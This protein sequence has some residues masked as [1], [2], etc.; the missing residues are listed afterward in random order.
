[1][2]AQALPWEEAA[3]GQRLPWEE[4]KGPRPDFAQNPPPPAGP[5]IQVRSSFG[6]QALGALVAQPIGGG[7]KLSREEEIYAPMPGVSE[8]AGL[9]NALAGWT[10]EGP[11]ALGKGFYHTETAKTPSDLA[12]GY[13]EMASGA[14]TT[15]L[16][17]LPFMAAAAPVATARV[18]AGGTAGGALAHKGAEY[19]GARPEYQDV[20]GDVGSLAGG[21]LAAPGV[22]TRIARLGPAVRDVAIGDQDAQALRGLG[23]PPTSKQSLRALDEVKTARPFLRGVKSEAELQTRIPQAKT[24]IWQPYK[25]VIDSPVGD[26]Q[27]QGPDGPTTIRELEAARLKSAAD[28]RATRKLQPQDQA[29]LERKQGT[30]A[31]LMERDRAI[32]AV[33]DPELERAG[34]NPQ[35]IRRVHGSVQGIESRVS[36]KSTLAEPTKPYGLGHLSEVEL[37]KPTTYVTPF[38]K[39]G[40]DLA[41]G[42]PWWSGRPTDVELSEGFRNAGPRPNFTRPVTPPPPIAGLLPAHPTPLGPVPEVAEPRPMPPPVEGTT[43]AQRLGLLLNHAP[44]ELGGEVLPPEYPPVLQRVNRGFLPAHEDVPGWQIPEKN[45][46]P[47]I[48][49]NV[50]EPQGE[51]RNFQIPRAGGRVEP[52]S[53]AP[54]RPLGAQPAAP[55]VPRIRVD[56]ASERPTIEAIRN[57]ERTQIDTGTRPGNEG[58][59]QAVQGPAQPV[60]PATP[61][62]ETIVR[63]PGEQQAY[64]ASYEIR[65]LADV[66]PSHS[67]LNFGPNKKYGLTNDRDYSNPLNQG[68]IVSASAPG[69]FDPNFLITDNPDAANGPTIIDHSGNALGGNARTMILQRVYQHNP[70]GAQAYRNLLAQKAQQFGIDPQAIANMKQPVLVRKITTDNP[71]LKQNAVTDFNKVGTAQ[72][73]PAERAIADSRR[74]SQ[75]T[76]DAIAGRLEQGGPDA[77]MAQILEGRSG[78]EVLDRL[79]DDGVIS[80]QE[81]AA[82]A[83]EDQLTPAGKDRISKLTIARF[84]R[85]PAQIDSTAPS[86]RSKM[87]SLAAPLARVDGIPGWDLTEHIQDALDLIE[88]ARAHNLGTVE[89]VI[90]QHGFFADAKY[91]PE[92]VMLAK[93]IKGSGVRALTKS[94][95]QYAQDAMD[96][97]GPQ[98]PLGGSVTQ[99]QAFQDAFGPR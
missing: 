72:M 26:R 64:P 45:P 11:L 46:E 83:N 28:L 92:A 50:T 82:F 23:V 8:G 61:G 94:V 55:T 21:T 98:Q 6:D 20:A 99:K 65:E 31:E 90:R 42:R 86:I 7:R 79:I 88:E 54:V 89:D 97:T 17:A 53:A 25:D 78:I 69:R 19:L 9:R 2:S 33:L 66:Q 49:R 14:G 58:T 56:N 3:Q 73:T 57:G 70:E 81:R 95:R 80:P 18:L 52:R 35:V 43:R 22:P 48:S 29:A 12:K 34:L 76:L 77:T 41:A 74:V 51:G 1:M 39:A 27:V 60:H 67:G 59:A 91:S 37:T 68:K 10:E 87:E 13:H 15:S 30:I 71:A 62:T 44:I 63:I 84:F 96:A 40:R 5:H 47:P 16:P 4:A 75:G 38:L 93:Q 36:G 24:E 85:D 32:K